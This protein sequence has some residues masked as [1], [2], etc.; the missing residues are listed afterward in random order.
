LFSAA[1]PDTVPHAPV[2]AGAFAFN[3]GSRQRE[4]EGEEAFENIYIYRLRGGGFI[5]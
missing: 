1:A 3:F 4:G 2:G 5:G